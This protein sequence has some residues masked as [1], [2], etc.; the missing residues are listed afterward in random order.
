VGFPEFGSCFPDQA[1][2]LANENATMSRRKNPH[3]GSD[4]EDFLHAE[5]I[6]DDVQAMALKKVIAVALMKQMKRRKITVS[7]LAS[8]LG[9]SRA[10]LHRVLDEEN[11]S[12]TLNT[13][14]RT[15]SALGCRLKLD[16]VAA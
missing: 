8:A 1:R 10:A 4:F 11:T 6:F 3:R 13:L 5:G 14:S 7:G 12:I 16:I 15:A 2:W 9:T